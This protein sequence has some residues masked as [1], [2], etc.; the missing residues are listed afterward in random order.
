MAQCYEH[1][2]RCDWATGT[3]GG[4]SEDSRSTDGE[5]Q[6]DPQAN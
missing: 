3:R 2:M 4:V 5:Q 6:L 1:R